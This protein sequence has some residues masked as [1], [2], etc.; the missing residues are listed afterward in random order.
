MNKNELLA[1]A[2]TLVQPQSEAAHD[3]SMKKDLLAEF[4]IKNLEKRKDLQNLIGEGNLSMMI[5]N[6]HNMARFM[7]SMFSAYNPRIFLETIL[8]VFRAYRSHG[9]HLTFWS[10]HLNAWIDAITKEL[11]P[12]S[13]QELIPFYNWIQI[14]IPQFSLLTDKEEQPN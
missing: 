2:S 14:N 9:F 1:S 13:A 8:W 12:E 11:E 4:V 5:D 10:A 3:F 7:N 6:A